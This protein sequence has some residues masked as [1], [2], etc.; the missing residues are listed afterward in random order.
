MT[1][2]TPCEKKGRERK[3]K[4]TTNTKPSIN[5]QQTGEFS[6]ELKKFELM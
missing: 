5:K 6:R 3:K 2:K 4:K 1:P